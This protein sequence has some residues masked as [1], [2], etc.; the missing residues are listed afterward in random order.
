MIIDFMCQRYSTP[1]SLHLIDDIED[2][3]SHLAV[4]VEFALTSQKEE[5]RIAEEYK[6]KRELED[7]MSAMNK[8]TGREVSL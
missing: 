8:M 6:K 1:P 4:N 7:Q 2:M 5:N 3:H